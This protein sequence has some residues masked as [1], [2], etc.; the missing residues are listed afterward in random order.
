MNNHVYIM[1]G[2]QTDFERNW[3]KEGKGVVALLRE[4]LCDG[5]QNANISYEQVAQLNSE[6]RVACYVGNALAEFYTQQTHLGAM[7]TEVHPAFF[8]VPA[9]RYEAACASGAAAIAAAQSGIRAGDYDVAIVVGWE[10]MKT[11]DAATSGDYIARTTYYAKEARGLDCPFPKLMGRIMEAYVARYGEQERM[12]SA[13]ARITEKNFANAKANPNAKTR[14]WFMNYDQ[15]NMRGAPTNAAIGGML[16]AADFARFADGAAVVVLCSEAYRKERG[17]DAA[18]PYIKGFGHRV[19]PMLLDWKLEESRENAYLLPW[20][21]QAVVEAYA[22]ADVRVED[23]DFFETHDAGTAMEYV[24]L[25]AFGIAQTGK[26]YLSVEQGDTTV[27]GKY[28][29]NPSGGL[30]GGGHPAGATGVR[31]FLDVY[32]QIA[33]KAGAY[34]LPKAKTGCMLNMGGS[35][36]TNFV[37]VVGRD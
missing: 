11:V 26:E 33:G 29:V 37:F 18:T 32:K 36:T 34:Q 9:T 1:G 13:L 15:A 17:L 12:L 28:P 5:L 25:S 10:M 4:A 7:L 16:A 3:S 21:R 30:L 35:A 6:N 2:A 20:T 14:Q 23:I 31:M 19:A 24:S 8:G 22:R 27:T